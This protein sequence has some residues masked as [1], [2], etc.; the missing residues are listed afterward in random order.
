MAQVG[1]ASI[2]PLRYS[3]LLDNC[4]SCCNY[5]PV[6]WTAWEF[7]VSKIF[8]R[9]SSCFQSELATK[10]LSA[11]KSRKDEII[12]SLE[13][14]VGKDETKKISHVTS[15]RATSLHNL[16][17]LAGDDRGAY[18][19]WSSQ[20]CSYSYIL[21]QG[22]LAIY[23]LAPAHTYSVP[24]KSPIWYWSLMTQNLGTAHCH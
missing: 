3:K 15:E 6:T 2:E 4:C 24:G 22:I 7:C 16:Q 20:V 1:C 9:T 17:T 12:D 21:A 11:L 13:D 14:L 8:D 23:V 19:I 18:S 5:Y 10:S